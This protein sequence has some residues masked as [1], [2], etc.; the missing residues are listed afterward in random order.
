MFAKEVGLFRKEADGTVHCTMQAV[1]LFETIDDL[2]AA[3]DIMEAAFDLP[4]YRQA[5]EAMRQFA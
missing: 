2:H 5:V 3:P 4:V 1:P